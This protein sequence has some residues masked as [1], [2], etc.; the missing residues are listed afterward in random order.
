MIVRRRWRRRGEGERRDCIGYGMWGKGYGIGVWVFW[1]MAWT[2]V[3]YSP[4]YLLEDE[5]LVV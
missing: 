1:I 3:F 2:A 5:V 4:G